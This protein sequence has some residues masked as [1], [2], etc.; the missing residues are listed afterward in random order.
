LGL[1]ALSA[2]AESVQ[3]RVLATTDL[4]GNIFPYD[5]Y[6]AK[7]AERGLAKIATL[8]QRER[9]A[10]TL[11]IDCG[12]TIQGS[13]L[14]TVHELAV[15]KGDGNADPRPD[16]MMLAMN[17]LRYDAMTV[18]NHEFNY[19]LANLSAA[20]KAAKFPWLAANVDGPSGFLPSITKTIAGVRVTVIGVVTPTIPSWERPENYKGLSFADPVARVKKIASDLRRAHQ[21]DIIIVAAHS[22]L[23]RDLKGGAKLTEDLPGENVAYQIAEQTPVD[24]VIFGHTHAEVGEFR[25]GKVVMMQPRNWG[26]S[27]GE[28]DF[29]LDR[30]DG[31]WTLAKVSSRTIP[32]NPSVAADEAILAIGKPYHAAAEAYLS[33]PVTRVNTPLSMEFS[34]V[35]D[36]ALID[37]IQ[38]VEQKESGAP[39]SFASAFITS[40][41]VPA[42]QMTVREVAALYPYDNTL[43]KISGTGK[44]IREALENSARFYKTCTGDC[45]TGPLINPSI[46]GYN[47]DMAQG[48]EYEIDLR[49]PEGSRIVNLRFQGQPLD[50]G[51]AV[52]IAVNSYRAGGSGGYSMFKDA[53][54]LWRSS[55]EIRDM[56][57]RY[58][59]EKGELPT[60][61]DGNWRVLPEAAHQEL[62]R[63]A[64]RDG[65][66]A[67]NK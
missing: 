25:V 26:M 65:V 14:E 18:G 49:K 38:A 47:Y 31:N 4:H 2:V 6:T 15:R 52:D 7:P 59:T 46:I 45:S 53:K 16:P 9:N 64:L 42:G 39:V 11:L 43:Y 17:Q 60:A 55:E 20:H 35:E 28:M 24:A 3:I 5:Y 57:I 22:G 58:Y 21:T 44:M 56:M 48:V 41:R 36:T 30:V 12:D 10:N 62:R 67:V 19:G 63:E 50:D 40:A 37:A 29:T 54:I 51:K 61:P 33:M 8:I 32:V 13:P 1:I 66:R 34:R 23:D 27:L